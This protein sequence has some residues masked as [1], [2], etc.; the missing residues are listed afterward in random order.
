M[1]TYTGKRYNYPVGHLHIQPFSL[2]TN[3]NINTLNKIDKFYFIIIIT[4][5]ILQNNFPPQSEFPATVGRF[6]PLVRLR[7]QT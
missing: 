4:S 5:N 7:V 6:C 1:S 3:L 2:G